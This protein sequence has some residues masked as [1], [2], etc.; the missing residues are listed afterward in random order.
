MMADRMTTMTISMS[1]RQA[2][3]TGVR[4]APLLEMDCSTTE[5][6][7][8]PR[9]LRKHQPEMSDMMTASVPH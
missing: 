5:S 2:E 4:A 6:R 7:L 9:A 1:R 8:L 3:V